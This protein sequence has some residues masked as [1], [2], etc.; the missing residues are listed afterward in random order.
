MKQPKVISKIPQGE[1]VVL[2]ESDSNYTLIYLDNGRK[3]ISGYNLKFHE[4][5]ADSQVF[6]RLNRSIMIHRNYVRG[7]NFEAFVLTLGNGRKVSIS[8][9]RIKAFQEWI[10]YVTPE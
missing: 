2:M 1:K 10:S 7:I 5:I 8:R 9:R 6:I 3:L 4:D